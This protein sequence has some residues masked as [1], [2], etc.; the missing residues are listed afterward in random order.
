M[1]IGSARTGHHDRRFDP[2]YTPDDDTWPETLPEGARVVVETRD[3]VGDDGWL[4][5]YPVR[6]T[7]IEQV[8]DEQGLSK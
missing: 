6:R 5:R 3:V 1:G 4:R 2:D 7:I 8:S